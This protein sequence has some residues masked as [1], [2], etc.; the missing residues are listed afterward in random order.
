MRVPPRGRYSLALAVVTAAAAGTR[1]AS[2][3][4][5]PGLHGKAGSIEWGKIHG[6][7]L[8]PTLLEAARHCPP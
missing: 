3:V 5:G 6:A 2:V 1:L 8:L 4:R 7:D